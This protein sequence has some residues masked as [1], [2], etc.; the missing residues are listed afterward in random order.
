[1]TFFIFIKPAG[2]SAAELSPSARISLITCGPGQEMYS[3]FG[4]SALW[5]YDPVMNIDRMYNYGTFDFNIPHFYWEF[6]KGRLYY[7]LSVTRSRSFFNEY[8]SEKRYIKEQLLNLLPEEKEELFKLLEINYLPE[9]RHYWYD[10][11]KDNCSTRIRDIVAKA[12]NNRFIWPAEPDNPLTFRQLLKPYVKTHRMERAGMFLLLSHGADRKA[13]ISDYMFLPEQLYRCFAEA[14]TVDGEVLVR[15]NQSL[16]EPETTGRGF[17]KADS[18]PILLVQLLLFAIGFFLDIKPRP[19]R[20]RIFDSV[21]FSLAGLLGI[22]IFFMWFF[23]DHWSCKANLNLVWANPLNLALVILAWIR[24]AARIVRAYSRLMLIAGLTILVTLP[25]WK[26]RIPAEG[27]LMWIIILSGYLR[28]SAF[29]KPL[30]P[31][32]QNE[33]N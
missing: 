24:P 14:R 19:K 8:I 20:S 31:K 3:Y 26:Q 11:F 7:M 10:F 30:N 4:H 15:E 1:L 33:A 21:M 2:S 5:V 13:T 12:T 17:R 28:F 16:F 18:I 25:L 23:S 32:Q 22:L 9:N 29:K 6:A 27:I